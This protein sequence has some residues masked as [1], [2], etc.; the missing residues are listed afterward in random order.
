LLDTRWL[1]LRRHLLPLIVVVTLLPLLSLGGFLVEVKS[2]P[3]HLRVELEVIGP[4][5]TDEGDEVGKP[6]A[7]DGAP[8][9]AALALIVEEEHVILALGLVREVVMLVVRG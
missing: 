2:L 8:S 4:L 1:S 5:V 9:N 3:S 6:V 7:Q